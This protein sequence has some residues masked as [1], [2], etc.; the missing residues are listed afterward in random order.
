MIHLA[1]G[2]DNNR[3]IRHWYV[4]LGGLNMHLKKKSG[5]V[6]VHETQAC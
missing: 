4:L 2:Y 1:N 6:P 5:A 3:Q